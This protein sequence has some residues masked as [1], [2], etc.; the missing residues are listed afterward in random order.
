[1][2]IAQQIKGVR[3]PAQKVYFNGDLIS[4][5]GVGGGDPEDARND[6]PLFVAG[7]SPEAIDLTADL[8]WVGA[9]RQDFGTVDGWIDEV[10]ISKGWRYG[11]QGIA[12]LNPRQGR[13]PDD[14]TI[15]LWTFDHEPVRGRYEDESG[16]GHA[17]F[18]GGSLAVSARGRLT[19][20]WA[21]LK[22]Q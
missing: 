16:N 4:S 18:L 12:D 10:R 6:L 11:A 7:L 5:N 9:E 15:A 2:H 17:L 1:M 22:Q 3:S 21:Q 13:G 14:D 19:T 8:A 20:T